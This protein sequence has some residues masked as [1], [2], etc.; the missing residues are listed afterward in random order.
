MG[1]LNI[2]HLWILLRKIVIYLVGRKCHGHG[3]Q[4][5]W[6]FLLTRYITIFLR[7]IQRWQIF[8][9]PIDV[10]CTLRGLV[11]LPFQ[12][13]LSQSTSKDGL[14]SIWVSPLPKVVWDLS[15]STSKCVLRSTSDR[16][17]SVHFQRLSEIDL[18]QSVHFKKVV[19][20]RPQI[21]L[22]QSTL[23]DL[24]TKF[25]LPACFL[26]RINFKWICWNFRM[27]KSMPMNWR[28][29]WKLHS[30]R[31]RIQWC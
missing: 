17:E 7:R 5:R 23:H 30:Q 9:I 24:A 11:T 14:R 10:I 26:F 2:C 1:I 27:L 4:R 22:S 6:H 12:I 18:S 29:F 25:V 15:Q 16:S 20:D 19:W 8:K 3:L 31:V 21:D 13:D 28:K